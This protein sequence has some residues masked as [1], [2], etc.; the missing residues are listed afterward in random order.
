MSVATC[1]PFASDLNRL[2][3]LCLVVLKGLNRGFVTG[4]Y[5]TAV[6][7]LLI[8]LKY[9]AVLQDLELACIPP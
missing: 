6:G 7:T 3:R 9:P 2:S 4:V 5:H 1:W 8:A